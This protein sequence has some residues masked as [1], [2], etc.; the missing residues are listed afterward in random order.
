MLKFCL[1]FAVLCEKTQGK[2]FFCVALYEK[3]H[4]AY[5][6]QYYFA[7]RIQAAGE[8]CVIFGAY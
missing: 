5:F 8:R 4:Q 7:D 3:I 6:L 2:R 1:C